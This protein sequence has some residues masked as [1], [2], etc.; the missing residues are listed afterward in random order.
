[1][2]KQGQDRSDKYAA[3]FDPTIIQSRYT[4]TQAIAIAG[5]VTMQKALA[6]KNASVRALLN[7]AGVFPILTVAY[8]AF[9]NKLFGICNRFAG[10]TTTP[11]L[12]P[13]A[14]A[15]ATAEL[16]KFMTY[17]GNDAAAYDIF[18]DIWA[19]YASMLGAAPCPIV[20]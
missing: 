5:Q 4:K 2:V 14:T 15:Q 10:L 18:A 17:M 12:S 16:V 9:S 1:M 3:K 19:L 7:A 11:S 20:A 13:T 6:E 8:Q